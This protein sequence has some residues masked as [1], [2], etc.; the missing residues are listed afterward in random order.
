MCN[1]K[2]QHI[3]DIKHTF[4]KAKKR[5]CGCFF[6]QSWSYS[7]FMLC[8]LITAV[9]SENEALWKRVFQL[10]AAPDAAL[11]GSENILL[12]ERHPELMT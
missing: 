6:N 5:A 9:I 11:T 1:C 4:Q 2:Q 10:L 3:K 12:K 7:P 8:T